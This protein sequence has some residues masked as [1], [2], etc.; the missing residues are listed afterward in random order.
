MTDIADGFEYV[1]TPVSD[2]TI[3]VEMVVDQN[4][5]NTASSQASIIVNLPPMTELI[6][7]I[8]SCNTDQNND[9]TTLN[10]NDLILSGDATGT[11]VD[12]D[13]SGATGTL[14]NL[15]F[16]GVT[17]GDYTFEYTTAAAQAPCENVAYTV[18]VTVLDCSCPDVSIA[19]AGPFCNDAAVLDL[20]TIT[21]TTEAG[22]WS[23]TDAPAS[24]T[25]TIAD[26]TFNGNGSVAGDYE[27][28]YTLT[29]IPP[30]GCPP[31]ASQIISISEVVSAGT[32][33]DTI[34]VCNDGTDLNLL[35]ALEGETIG[36]TWTDV[37]ASPATGFFNDGILTTENLASGIYNFVYEVAAN[38]PC[39][40]DNIE[41]V[42]E[43]D[44]PV[45]AGTL[46]QNM[47]VCDGDN[48]LVNLF[49]LIEGYDLGGT[50]VDVSTSPAN[51]FDA[52]GELTTNDLAVGNYTFS[53]EVSSNGICANDAV[54]VAVNLN[55]TPIADA[56][57]TSILTC[58][59]P[60]AMIGGNSSV[61]ENIA[62]LWSGTVEDSIAAM[63]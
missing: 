42:V 57:E 12:L 6:T 25:A 19:A 55:E 27:L 29:E 59:E 45:E 49:D 16:D 11:W 54:L 17:A 9:P 48:M 35:D 53:Y 34:R 62:Y 28:T 33:V 63:T 44:A 40:N 60:T 24:S 36:G 26:N 43:I 37:S 52:I 32:I 50:W 8:S 3:A 14:P 30:V 15:D 46:L 58:D 51:G 1:L 41:I 2:T 13:A 56:G 10:L 31:S 18:I 38:A 22:T 21:T 7:T 47:G 20:A 23:I 5:E 61:G 39:V 4:C